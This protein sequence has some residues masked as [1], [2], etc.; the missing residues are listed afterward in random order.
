MLAIQPIPSFLNDREGFIA[1]KRG[2]QV[3]RHRLKPHSRVSNAVLGTHQLQFVAGARLGFQQH[4]M[5]GRSGK[6]E[7]GD[8][9][10]SQQYPRQEQ[11]GRQ[12]AHTDGLTG[13]RQ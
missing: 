13:K 8:Q 3:D 12:I 7:R 4:F 10:V 1:S 11:A 9:A 2:L 6:F 5:H